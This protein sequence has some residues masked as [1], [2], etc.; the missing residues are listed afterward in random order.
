M[1]KTRPIQEIEPQIL[2]QTGGF[3]G[4]QSADVIEIYTRPPL[5][6]TATKIWE[7]QR[8]ND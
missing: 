5:V 7:F 1:A 3:R 2:H 8:E 4:R 6:A